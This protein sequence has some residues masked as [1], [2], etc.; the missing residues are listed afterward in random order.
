M[1]AAYSSTLLRAIG[2]LAHTYSNYHQFYLGQ[3][4]LLKVILL[5]LRKTKSEEIQK[6][7]GKM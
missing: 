1:E 2:K 5:G 4:K 3:E 7:E 6:I